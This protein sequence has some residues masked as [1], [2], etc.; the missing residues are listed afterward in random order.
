[1][2]KSLGR[3]RDPSLVRNGAKNWMDLSFH[4]SSLT[5]KEENHHNEIWQIKSL[6]DRTLTKPRQME[7]LLK[8]VALES[9]HP[10]RVPLSP[11]SLSLQI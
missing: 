4:S 8:L 10:V 11:P 9:P 7:G 2:K 5:I 1:M 3:S 6:R